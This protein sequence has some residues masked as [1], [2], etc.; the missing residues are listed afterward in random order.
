MDKKS[1]NRLL[2]GL[3]VVLLLAAVYVVTD[4]VL[5]R[6]EER[7]RQA[8]SEEKAA[9]LILSVS[10]E[11]ISRITFPGTEGTIVLERQGDT[12]ISPDDPDFV[13]DPGKVERL[14][15][16]LSALVAERTID[17]GD[18]PAKYGLG[19]DAKEIRI[20]LS[21]GTEKVIRVGSRNDGNHQLYIQTDPDSGT[22]FLTRTAL[23]TDFDGTLASFALYE[24]FPAFVPARIREIDVQK[25]DGY[26]LVTPGDD[27]CTVTGTDGNVQSAD[28]GTVG[29]VQ[30]QLSNT[31]W[32]SNIDDHCTDLSVYALDDPRTVI[33]I[34]SEGQG[35]AEE[36]LSTVTLY[37]GDT[38]EN[39]NY[40]VRLEG[41]SQ[42]HT[43]RR[44]Y[45][46]D[47]AENGPEFFWSLAYSFVSIGD[48]DR[49]EVTAMGETHVL[50]RISE[51]GRQTDDALHW[52]VD[53]REV[54]KD[55]FTDF[56]YACV[57]VTAQER[58][59]SVPELSGEPVLTL[60]YFLTDG[61]EKQISYYETD[62]NFAT[63]LY[64][65]DT[66]AASTNRLYV[67]TMLDSLA[68]LIKE[69]GEQPHAIFI[70]N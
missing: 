40:Y 20:E 19:S 27:S 38:D 6:Q 41:S 22:V 35:G 55:A 64:D 17:G 15:G 4:Q 67:N 1:R 25:E 49:L 34:S 13:M 56:Y 11:E 51:D 43:V 14:T 44:E 30:Q 66:K 70:G 50:K 2:A 42:V 26:T 32:L 23:D 33:R 9:S 28:L 21:D 5:Q 60:R 39:G 48:L 65:N 45:L 62:Q 24:E 69:K 52:Y 18:D 36:P 3:L 37:L 47:L 54:E 61:S 16:D 12:F 7:E 8:Q 46:A 59:A 58:L 10:P 53:D 68:A 29:Q 31:S 63:V 57:S